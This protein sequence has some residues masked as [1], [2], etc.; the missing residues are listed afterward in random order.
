M[1]SGHPVTVTTKGTLVER[2]DRY[3]WARWGQAGL[4]RV[5]LVG[6]TT[7]DEGR[8]WRRRMEPRW[9]VA[10][11]ASARHRTLKPGGC[12]VRVMVSPIVPGAHRP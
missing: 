10:R 9:S 4:S 3:P 12:P 8:I 2:D 7:L 1:L 11:A 5:G 6:P